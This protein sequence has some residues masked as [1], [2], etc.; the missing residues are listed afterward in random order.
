VQFA[1]LTPQSL[2]D[3]ANA[4]SRNRLLLGLI[5]SLALVSLV[6]YFE[7]RSIVRTLRSLAD[8][9]QGIA[10]GRLH[11]RVPVHGRDEF[12]LLGGAFND[13]ANQL[14]AR[15]AELGEERA[16]LRD[17]ITRF[18]EA[19]AAT[20][21]A[22]QLL[23]VIVEAAVEAT[24]AR[25]ARLLADDGTIVESGD[26]D[27]AGERLEFALSAARTA[28]GTLS[29]VGEAF[30]EEQR[31]AASSLASHATIALENA[32]LHR[33]VERQALVDG[34]TG[35]ANRRQCEDAL[36]TEIAQADRLGTPL[37]LVLADLDDFKGVNDVHGHAVGDD[38]LREFAS[39]L[40]STLR[41]SDLAGRWGGEEFLLLL[42]G[43]DAD[44]GAHLADRVRAVLGERAFLG[45][46]G[47]V[48]NVT[49]SFGVAQH[50]VGGTE[51]DLFAAAD[52]A[53]YHAKRNGKNRVELE[54]LVRSF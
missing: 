17:A 3:A 31:M 38:V 9:A 37:T 54:Q 46:D 42:P 12:A 36:T 29:I 22:N 39:V 41:D 14:Q 2:I 49:C 21:D 24:G 26:P 40:R 23:R 10:R 33:I 13:M 28:F 51:R 52:Q 45:R 7:G 47:E 5:A 32:R 20:H 34:L 53:L 50:R 30:D 1:V 27:A 16:R 43:A 25:G 35:I 44:G 4:S 11:E 19:L 6:A 18:G 48:V 15:I 8:A